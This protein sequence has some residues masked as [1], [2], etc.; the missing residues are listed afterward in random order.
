[1]ENYSNLLVFK[2]SANLGPSI[3]GLKAQWSEFDK[4]VAT[5]TFSI[6][7]E[8]TKTENDAIQITFTAVPGWYNAL[9]SDVKAAQDIRNNFQISLA[10]DIVNAYNALAVGS[11]LPAISPTGATPSSAKSSSAASRRAGMAVGALVA[12]AAGAVFL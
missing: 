8:V 3:T 4:F 6:P 2:W 11:P 1:M 9:P 7:P 5:A 10:A 12:A